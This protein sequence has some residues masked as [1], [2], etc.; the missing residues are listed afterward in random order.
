MLH[1]N[2]VT[3]LQ[4]LAEHNNR[5]WFDANRAAYTEA[6]DDFEKVVGELLKGL[7]ATDSAYAGQKAKDC[8]FRIFRDVRFGKDKTPYKPNFGAAFSKGGKKSEVAGFYLHIEPGGKSFIGGGMWM[9]EAGILKKI[10]QEIDYNFADFLA[11]TEN[12]KFKQL[13]PSIE[14][15]KLK[16]P[17]QG[18]AAD[19]P[20]IEYLKLK[21][22]VATHNAITIKQLT[23]PGFVAQCIHVFTTMQPFINFLNRAVD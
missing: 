5:P 13:F 18:Y 9:P 8:V 7:E 16:T 21:S 6:K 23:S 11:I 12:K 22:F 17:P 15:E 4:Q 10:R 2:T 1:Q 20:A 3:F 19:N 14:G